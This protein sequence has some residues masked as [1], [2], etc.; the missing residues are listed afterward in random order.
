M[1]DEV[2]EHAPK[3]YSGAALAR[4]LTGKSHKYS[5]FTDVSGKAA[6][7]D[8]YDFSYCIFNRAYFHNSSFS[9]CKFI[10]AHFIDCNFRNAKLRNCDFSYSSFNGTKIPTEEI[11]ENLPPWPNVR[12]EFLQILRRNAASV[13]D[14]KAEKIFVI[15]E[16]RFPHPGI[17]EPRRI[18]VKGIGI[19]RQR[20]IRPAQSRGA[21][22]RVK[23]QKVKRIPRD[24]TRDR[25]HR[26]N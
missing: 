9:N 12:R 10:G 8:D 18:V 22:A 23:R 2:T 5:H 1:T 26:E 4:V 6:K 7:F 16:R 17:S 14:Y 3:R 21:R 19:A 24:R 11:I 25:A 15:H 13:G 20:V